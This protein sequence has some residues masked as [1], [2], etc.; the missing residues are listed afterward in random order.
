MPKNRFSFRLVGLPAGCVRGVERS[1]VAL[2]AALVLVIGMAA[3]GQAE[4]TGSAQRD[5]GGAAAAASPELDHVPGY[6][7]GPDDEVSV[8]VLGS[9]EISSEP[10]RIGPHG[11]LSMPL[12]GRVAAAG[13]TLDQLEQ[14]LRERLAT[15][16]REPRVSV[17]VARFRSRP[18]SVLGAVNRPGV[19]QVE[20]PK[21]LVEMLSLAEGISQDAG[22]WA[23][24]TRLIKNG[25]IPLES[26][27]TDVSGRFSVAEVRL[28]DLLEA[29]RPELNIAVMPRDVIAV[30][31]AEMVYV[32]GGVHRSGG[33]LLNDRES[34]TGLQALALAG[35]LKGTAKKKAAKIL[36]SREGVERVEIPVN[37]SSIMAGRSTDVPMEREDILFVPH[38]GGKAAVKR[39][40]EAGL[41]MG[42]GVM[43]WRAGRGN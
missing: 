15:Y 7:L 1:G 34:L 30:P 10:L 32:I 6:V 31:R 23:K 2:L 29:R 36:R 8:Q 37:L 25:V 19:H 9:D 13:K 12:A 21:S 39:I 40:A 28:S 41:A 35:G 26:A 38:S 3:P 4:T 16:I 17:G 27:R 22:P 24:I 20:G 5:V 18:V 33:F 14:L 11:Y 42:T 43:V